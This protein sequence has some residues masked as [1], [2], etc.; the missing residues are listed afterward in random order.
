MYHGDAH[1]NKNWAIEEHQNK[2]DVDQVAKIADV[3]VI[4][5][6]IWYGMVCGMENPFGQ[7]RSA[8]L[9]M[10]TP[11]LLPTFSLLAFAGELEK[12]A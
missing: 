9:A 12:Q 1:I 6:G 8:A 5:N 10:S 3:Q 11:H 4:W 2:Q 7:S